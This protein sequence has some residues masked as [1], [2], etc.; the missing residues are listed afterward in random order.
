MKLAMIGLGKMGANMVRRLANNKHEIIAY[1]VLHQ[2][3]LDLEDE[4]DSVSAADNLELLLTRLPSPRIIWLM[5]P[6]QFV[7]Q[8]IDDLLTAGLAAGDVVIDGGNSNYKLSQQ[9]GERLQQHNMHFI[10]SGTSG[11]VWGLDNGYSLMV[12]GS[13]EAVALVEP[14]FKSLAP[15]SDTGWGHVGPVG[16]GHYVKMVH[17]G[18]EYGM[19][20]AYAEGFELMKAKDEM[21]FDMHQISRIWQH[22]SV[23]RSWLLDL[24]A[25]ALELDVEM[26]TVSDFVD[27]SGEG[28]WVV[29]DSIE[30]AVPTPVLTLA[31][32][33]RFR[34]RQDPSYA[35]KVLNAMRA[36]FGG[37]PIKAVHVVKSKN[38]A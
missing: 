38:N 26:S 20:Q 25:D 12:G 21:N 35:G 11:G 13:N 27:D 8:T 22:G 2:T 30:E 24:I 34:S 31:L 36:G 23:I 7:D 32:Q 3:A 1:D 28:R 19:M 17:N 4:L 15:S 29:Q 37:H 10:D 14:I 6:H 33:M 16:A 18:I 9:R 5:V